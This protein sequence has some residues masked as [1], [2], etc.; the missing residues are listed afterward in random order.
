MTKSPCTYIHKNSIIVITIH[1]LLDVGG[2]FLK[3]TEKGWI[4]ISIQFVSN[5]PTKTKLAYI[6]QTGHRIK[7]SNK[8]N[9]W[10]GKRSDNET[11]NH[12]HSQHSYKAIKNTKQ[13]Y[14]N[15]RIRYIN[16]VI[17]IDKTYKGTPQK[18]DEQT[19]NRHTHS[20]TDPQN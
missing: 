2:L 18:R 20:P 15:T 14:Q 5:T 11:E 17:I 16:R 7:K 13:R 9:L 12:Y 6:I 8:R 1:Y 3:N 10:I 19:V 4:Y